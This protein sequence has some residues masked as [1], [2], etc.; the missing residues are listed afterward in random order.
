M[1]YVFV[2]A[3]CLKYAIEFFSGGFRELFATAAT[4]L[5]LGHN[6]VMF[7][8]LLPNATAI[9]LDPVP[10]IAGTASFQPGP[11]NRERKAFRA[12][13]PPCRLLELNRYFLFTNIHFI[14]RLV[15]KT[16]NA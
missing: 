12:I 7:R 6:R 14:F 3:W 5:G 8:H 11:W 10:E 1:Y 4:A 2:E 15:G 9:A 16:I 13:A